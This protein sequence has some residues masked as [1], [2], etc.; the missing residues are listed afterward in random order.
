LTADHR[1]RPRRRGQALEDAILRATMEEIAAVGYENLRIERVAERSRTGKASVY[2]RWPGKVSLVLAAAYHALPDPA[3]IADTG[4]L[5]GDL[6]GVIGTSV[7]VVS[8]P[9]GLAL[10]GLISEAI[11]DP[12]AANELNRHALNRTAGALR[13]AV[14]RAHDRGEVDLRRITEMQLDAA[15]LLARYHLLTNSG[16]MS[17]EGVTR[18]VDEIA[19]PLLLASRRDGDPLD[20][21]GPPV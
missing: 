6:I 18:L 1:R 3:D 20:P 17:L 13:E 14:Q 10:R 16:S 21:R 8:G 9:V 19:L 4:T 11:I 7:D 2:R 12:Q 5:R 15:V